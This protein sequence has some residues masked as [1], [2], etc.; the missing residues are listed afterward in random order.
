MRWDK[1][2]RGKRR[3]ISKFLLFPKN[4]TTDENYPAMTEKRWLE[5]VSIK[6]EYGEW[7]LIWEKWY[8]ISWYDNERI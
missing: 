2:R 1:P 7:W 6:Q 8:D 3:I 4:L 5:W